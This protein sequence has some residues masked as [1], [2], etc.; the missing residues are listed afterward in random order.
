M[1]TQKELKKV[2]RY[3]QGTG[4]F[5]WKIT[6]QGPAKIDGEAGFFNSAG[7]GYTGIDGKYYLTHRLAWLYVHGYWPEP[8]I[9]HKNGVRNDNRIDNLREVTPRCNAQNCGIYSHNTSG[10]PGVTWDKDREKWK[11]QIQI[12]GKVMS[13]GRYNDPL[14]AA[15]A[16]HTAEVWDSRWSCNLRGDLIK[17]IKQAWP[18]LRVTK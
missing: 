13:L 12:H 5:Y 17:A 14:E 10:F 2:L 9:D 11:A 15:L 8:Q 16:R 7:Y 3:N 1:I 6:K 18:Q 4:I